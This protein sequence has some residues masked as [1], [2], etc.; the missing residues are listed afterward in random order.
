MV[1]TRDKNTRGLSLWSGFVDDQDAEFIGQQSDMADMTLEQVVSRYA[2]QESRRSRSKEPESK[3]EI[4]A[5]STGWPSQLISSLDKYAV[6]TEARSRATLTKCGIY[7]ISYWFVNVLDLERVSLIYDETD[8]AV[9]Q[10]P[11]P[12]LNK[13]LNE[14]LESP[15]YA[16]PEPDNK[17]D[18]AVAIVGWFSKKVSAFAKSLGMSYITLLGI[19]YEWLLTT[20]E[21]ANIDPTNITQRYCRDVRLLEVYVQERAAEL[22]YIK[23]VAVGRA[24]FRFIPPQ[25]VNGRVVSPVVCPGGTQALGT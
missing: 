6:F 21:Q 17:R 9:R 10:I 25:I 11:D 14:R 15:V 23:R 16:C 20:T 18:A 19:G 7:P 1:A 24:S 12:F 4:R 22:D 13:T 5:H 3:A 2:D 8:S